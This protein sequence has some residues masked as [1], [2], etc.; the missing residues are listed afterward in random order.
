[1]ICPSHL[2]ISPTVV[3]VKIKQEGIS[4]MYNNNK[5][6]NNKKTA[7][8]NNIIL[9]FLQ[10]CRRTYENLDDKAG[11]KLAA[12]PGLILTVSPNKYCAFSFFKKK[13]YP[14][15][16]CTTTMLYLHSIRYH[17]KCLNTCIG[18]YDL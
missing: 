13:L 17:H 15:H 2:D 14:V 10:Y 16:G 6:K 9:D 11:C 12:I 7:D 4:L 5:N 1:M 3:S 8:N 18:F